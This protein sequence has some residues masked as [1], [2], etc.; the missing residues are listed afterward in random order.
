MKV[1]SGIEVRKK[2]GNISPTTF[3][4]LRKNSD[5]PK[6]MSLPTKG[7]SWDE[8]EVDAW[9]KALPKEAEA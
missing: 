7:R 9:L 8:A 3:W 2:L 5:F 4:K 6:P 1:I